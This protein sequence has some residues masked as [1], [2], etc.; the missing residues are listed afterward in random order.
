[1]VIGLMVFLLLVQSFNGALTT[2][3]A[4]VNQPC[5]IL[6]KHITIQPSNHEPYSVL[7]LSL[8]TR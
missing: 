5:S 3:P 1:M 6:K 4:G 7:I 8:S 2:K